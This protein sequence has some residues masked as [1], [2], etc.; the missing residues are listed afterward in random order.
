MTGVY[1]RHKVKTF[2][3]NLY[4]LF[5]DTPLGYVQRTLIVKYG[6]L[7]IILKVQLIY[8]ALLMTNLMFDTHH[9]SLAFQ[10]GI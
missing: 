9:S 10:I 8:K 6:F 5:R 7:G 1:Y 4:V 2:K 3:P